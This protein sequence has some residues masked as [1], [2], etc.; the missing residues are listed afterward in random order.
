MGGADDE[1]GTTICDEETGM[2]ISDDEAGTKT[3]DDEMML[4]SGTPFAGGTKAPELS[5]GAT[6]DSGATEIDDTGPIC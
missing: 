4:E 3:S 6:D 2:G 1:A 5:A